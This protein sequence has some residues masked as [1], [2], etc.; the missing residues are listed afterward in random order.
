MGSPERREGRVP[1]EDDGN[2]LVDPPHLSAEEPV[3]EQNDSEN[4][5]NLPPSP[6]TI[7]SASEEP[8]QAQSVD[9]SASL[10]TN[11]DGG[12]LDDNSNDNRYNHLVAS[13]LPASR[14]LPGPEREE[15][16]VKER[17]IDR[18][19]QRRKEA[20]RARL[21]RQFALMSNGGG[22]VYD[23]TSTASQ[24]G[25][26]RENNSVCGTVGEESSVAAHADLDDSMMSPSHHQQD[27][28]ASQEPHELGYTMERFL[29]ERGDTTDQISHPVRAASTSSS[30]IPEE[31]IEELK[32]SESTPP[33]KGV[34]M[35]RFLNDPVLLDT[36]PSV[37]E[38]AEE[39]PPDRRPDDVHRS[40]SFDMELR[41]SQINDDAVDESM[42]TDNATGVAVDGSHLLFSLDES[43]ASVQVEVA[44]EDIVQES[45]QMDTDAPLGSTEPMDQRSTAFTNPN[46]ARDN[47][48]GD[49]E[50]RVL[51]LTEAEIQ[52]MA[53]IEEASI[54][55]APPSDRDAESLVG[56]LVGD[57]GSPSAVG[58][59]AGT[60]FSQGTPTTAMESGS[61]FSGNQMGNQARDEDDRDNPDHVSGSDIDDMERNS[62]G[63]VDMSASVGGASLSGS[64]VSLT[65]NPPSEII[66]RVEPASTIMGG[67]D[68]NEGGSEEGGD[69]ENQRPPPP[70]VVGS[71]SL[72]H[73]PSSPRARLVVAQT[74]NQ[75]SSATRDEEAAV[76][77]VREECTSSL[78]I[79]EELRASGPDSSK[80]VNRSMRPG[81]VSSLGSPMRRIS[82][83]PD[84]MHTANSV[85]DAPKND[86]TVDG[87]DFDKN[88]FP[89][90]PRSHMS[91][92]VRDLPGDDFWTSPG[93]KMTVSPIHEE[94]RA[95]DLESEA[96]RMPDIPSSK[97]RNQDP[98]LAP[99]EGGSQLPPALLTMVEEAHG[100][101]RANQS[102]TIDAKESEVYVR[103]DYIAKGEWDL[104]LR[105]RCFL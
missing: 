28:D 16:T 37:A 66:G 34:V 62:M 36:T 49:E 74:E 97:S 86:R 22:T 14:L 94:R 25:G 12:L 31:T 13:P 51:R 1:N 27:E 29:Q 8:H 79:R 4:L 89:L 75:S 23:G 59:P 87:F 64:A 83:L 58:D 100:Q 46:D 76:M 45:A 15:P 10:L 104:C 71:P 32:S 17:L 68:G 5:E 82:S 61:M 33:D 9:L 85:E 20:E 44:P 88:D 93:R 98:L 105:H 101:I 47:D 41:T 81:M 54:G 35:E 43:N 78:R 30:A 11:P 38:E 95:L 96:L 26:M 90:S 80:I 63:G 18:E 92:S 40:V 103:K 39:P 53:A 84:K 65:A 69:D 6:P 19:R 102:A 52:E 91:D 72:S 2:E 3:L 60:T 42:D 56:D 48:D 24:N 21:K 73:H 67:E 55:N 77:P 99:A 7:I 57:F 50:P 70:L